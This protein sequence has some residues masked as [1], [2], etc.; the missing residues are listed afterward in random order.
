MALESGIVVGKNP[1]NPGQSIVL[2]YGSRP[3]FSNF[4]LSPFKIGKVKFNCTEQY[5]QHKKALFFNDHKSAN[6]ILRTRSPSQQKKL[7]RYVKGYDETRWRE[8]RSNVMEMGC[9]AKFQQN[10]NAKEQLLSTGDAKLAECGPTDKIWAIGLTL[11]D[12]RALNPK[13]WTGQNL[14]GTV[15]EKVRDIIRSEDES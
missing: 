6:K 7:G 14:M 11:A 5:F 12:H 1:E 10:Q 3:I 9:L 2:F 8:V 15:L 4:Y 13:K